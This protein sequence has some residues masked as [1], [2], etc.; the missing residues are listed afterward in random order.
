MTT[1]MDKSCLDL[2]AQVLCYGCFAGV[3][4]LSVPV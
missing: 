4:P 3:F 2:V 1:L